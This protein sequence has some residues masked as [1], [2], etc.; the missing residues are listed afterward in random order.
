MKSLTQVVIT[1]LL[2]TISAAISATAQ[3]ETP[4]YS[5][6][7]KNDGRS[8]YTGLVFHGNRL[9]GTTLSGG[10]AGLGTV[11]ALNPPSA[12]QTAWT[13]G[14]LHC[15]TGEGFDGSSPFS[16]VIAD[17][18]GAL[19]GATKES[20]NEV[21]CGLIYK[22]TPP[23]AGQTGWIETILYKFA[24]GTDGN[25]PIGGLTM[26]STGALY[27][28]TQYGGGA[29][30]GTVYKLTPPAAGQTLWTKTIL[31]H[32]AEG[33]DGSNPN[34]DLLLDKSGTLLGTTLGGG[35]YGLGTVFALNP[36]TLKVHSWTKTIIHDFEG[37]ATD[38]HDG[39]TPNGGLVGAVGQVFGTTQSGGAAIPCCGIVY[40]LAQEIAGSP[41]YTLNI[42]HIFTGGQDG[43]IPNAG[44]FRDASEKNLWGTTLDG[45]AGSTG[46]D[47]GTIFKLTR[48]EFVDSW[49]YGVVYSFNGGTNDGAFPGSSLTV[50]KT[51]NLYGTTLGGGASGLG[52]VYELTP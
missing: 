25:S 29:G 10:C 38:A 40:E 31:H 42:L 19:Y 49:T 39:A 17:S 21:C 45:G 12:G 13:R 27:G 2:L 28:S 8:P 24:G 35:L 11:Y 51:G 1:F 18:K 30:G 37:D 23:A 3:I 7:A 6:K 9:F 26:D 48:G 14:I 46:S 5:F 33:S 36:P 20:G 43:A 16:P 50:D 41:D 15:F 44:L 32:F 47:D 4:L 34:G 52:T 22:L